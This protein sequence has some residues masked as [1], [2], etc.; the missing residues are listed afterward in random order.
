MK[1]AMRKGASR[2]IATLLSVVMLTGLLPAGAMASAASGGQT[3]EEFARIVHLDIGRKYFSPETIMSIIDEMAA[4]GYN[5]LELDFGN[6]GEGQIR[7]KL[8]DMKVSYTY[9]TEGS[10][11]VVPPE[12]LPV[13]ELPTEP[14]LPEETAPVEPTEPAVPEETAPVEP[15]E[16]VTPEETAPVEPTEPVTPEET[17]PVEPT[18]PAVPEETAPVEPTEPATPEETAPVE[19]TEPA[20]PEETAPVEP[21]EPA[22]PEESAPVEPTEPAAPEE[23]APAESAGP[24]TPAEGGTDG[25]LLDGALGGV[26]AQTVGSASGGVM[27]IDVEQVEHTMT[28]DLEPVFTDAY[29]NEEDMESILSYAQ[30]LG[31]QVVPL[32]NTPGHMG[33]ILGNDLVTT[34][35]NGEPVE[36]DYTYEDTK[37]LDIT[38]DAARAF[39]VALVEKYASW[40]ADRGCTIFNIGADEFANDTYTTGGMGFGRL[41]E[42]G[43]YE[44]F[45]QYVTEL[46]DMLTEELGYTT[47]R[48]FNDGICYDETNYSFPDLEICYWSNGW[49]GYNVASAEFLH[50][51]GFDLINTHGDYYY[52]LGKDSTMTANSP[53]YAASFDPD[54]FQGE[55]DPITAGGAMFCVWCDYPNAKSETE[56]LKEVPE[57]LKYFAANLGGGE[58]V[59]KATGITVTAPGV[60]SVTVAANPD[61]SGV[62]A[63]QDGQFQE[64]VAYDVTV[65]GGRYTGEAQV[66]LPVPTDWADAEASQLQG[67]VVNADTKELEPGT[68]GTLNADGTYTFTVPHFSTVVLTLSE[69]RIAGGS[70]SMAIGET[71]SVTVQDV[72]LTPY[73]GSVSF[74]PDGVAEL[75]DITWDPNQGGVELGSQVTS[76]SSGT[77]YFITDGQ[78]NYL[79]LSGNGGLTNSNDPNTAT[80]WTI[81]SGYNIEADGYYLR[82]SDG[83]TT[84]TSSRNATDWDYGDGG[85]YTQVRVVFWTEDRYIGTSEDWRGNVSWG[86]SQSPDSN[87]AAYEVVELPGEGGIST[88]TF[89]GLNEGQTTA[90]IGDYTFDLNVSPVSLEGVNLAVDYFITNQKITVDGNTSGTINAGAGSIFSEGGARFEDVVSPTG[91]TAEGHLAVFWKGTKLDEYHHQHAAG[92]EGADTTDRTDQGYDFTYIRYWDGAWEV[93]ADGQSWEPVSDTD[94]IVAYYLQRTE[95][96]DEV[97]TD[98]V[99]WGQ[100]FGEW[101]QN[102]GTGHWF[103]GGYVEN[104][105]KY[106]FLDFA[107]VYE[108]NT[109]NPASFPV[110][111]T[112]FYHFD[113]CSAQNPRVL[114]EI[115]FRENG[116]FEIWK[117]TVQDGTS[118]GYRSPNRFESEYS[119]E[120]VTVWDESYGTEP[121]IDSLRYY[122]N[123]SG[124][125]VRI[126]VR[127]KQT[128]DSLTVHYREGTEDSYT[129]FYNYNISVNAGTVFNPG[130][131]LDPT[132][133]E[134]GLIN[135]SVVNNVGEGVTQWVTTDLSTMPEIGAEFRGSQYTCTAAVRSADGREVFLYYTFNDEAYKFVADYGLPLTISA[136]DLGLDDNVW[137]SVE[138]V[139]TLTYGKAETSTDNSA[140]LTYTPTSIIQGRERIRLS[141]S[142]QGDVVTHTI[143]IYPASTVYYEAEQSGF[144]SYSSG[145]SN[146][147]R[148]PIGVQE[149]SRLGSSSVYGSDSN[150]DIQS[151]ADDSRGGSARVTVTNGDNTAPTASF[152]FTGRAV[153]IIAR[154]DNDSGIIIAEIARHSGN[155]LRYYLVNNYYTDTEPANGLYQIPVLR[156]AAG[157]GEPWG[158]YDVTIHVLP[159][160]TAEEGE[161]KGT[162]QLVG[163]GQ[164]TASST[165]YLDAIRVYETLQP[166]GDYALEYALDGEA[167]PSFYEVGASMTINNSVWVDT[168]PKAD[169]G[170]YENEGPNNEV[171]LDNGQSIAVDLSGIYRDGQN[172]F[173]AARNME[174]DRSVKLT[175]GSDTIDVDGGSDQ[176]YDIT[177]FAT[178]SAALTIENNS[179]TR[180]AL[181]TLK[182][183]DKA[184]PAEG[185]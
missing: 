147:G 47:V 162:D 14:V 161:M 11:Q 165:F 83:L 43:H 121:I 144:L 95:I 114:N 113:G 148:A 76:I 123:R 136:A 84:T 109:Q 156:V 35:E 86:A 110:D 135:N 92:E 90:T 70:A 73:E 53:S 46:Y 81:T 160:Y 1:T 67:W 28:V 56:I 20:T 37:S 140:L 31:I 169:M 44:Y 22:V 29:L 138:V 185:N 6:S 166:G 78:G 3:G 155:T 149:T 23:T 125:L 59:D 89:R 117:I 24:E 42:N 124:K 157:D 96:T 103:W 115:Y 75:V 52:I 79:T 171:Y 30:N 71:A 63:L 152:T 88:V 10:A 50:R 170:Q 64:F 146:T 128:E 102:A 55:S 8:D 21:T 145:W 18:E 151:G 163:A 61:V 106:V 139:N 101:K 17:A 143:Y 98:V 32:L 129:E 27:V 7:F 179:G 19:P 15:T 154:T 108:D 158:T 34:D 153:D 172:L 141:L 26:T 4:L 126:Y 181:T 51:N 74:A 57:Y 184:E 174:D 49:S 167:N 85:F 36:V 48:A 131:A 137:T 119:G 127:T 45:A 68:G 65:N 178:G 122:E 2:V 173:L 182:V 82:Y 104:G 38:S 5:Q 118:S 107:V 91:E 133:E 16:P 130:F 72:D 60:S 58:A 159:F 41:V 168:I 13:N 180:I 87:G 105:S 25:S 80:R 111:D 176:Y 94:Q 69:A 120:E 33:A 99:D 40:F 39:G 77:E 142:D 93:S 66:T 183:T 112:W 177:D 9:Y 175:V 100:S 134:Y 62:A 97:T 150:Y 164:K 132:N 54:M 116:N 12:E